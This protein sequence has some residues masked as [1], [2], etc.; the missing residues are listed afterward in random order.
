MGAEPL[1]GFVCHDGV[2]GVRPT[3]AR[4]DEAVPGDGDLDAAP[5]D[6]DDPGC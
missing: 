6:E 3:D 4:L 2:V 1:A 5:R